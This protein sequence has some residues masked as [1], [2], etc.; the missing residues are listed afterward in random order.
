MLACAALIAGCDDTPNGNGTP[1]PLPTTAS[2]DTGE[3]TTEGTDTETAQTE[4]QKPSISIANAPIGGSGP[5][6]EG[7]EQCV[8]VNWLG[9]NPLPDG[10]TVKLGSIGLDPE[11]IFELYQSAC[12]GDA[13]RCTD[14][15]WSSES[16]R[17]C[18]VGGRQVANG[19]DTVLVIISATA[20]CA[21]EDDC[22]SLTEGAGQSSVG[23]NPGEL[24]TPTE[25][26]SDG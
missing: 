18:Y 26:P 24:E 12:P 25:T 21:T 23:F 4:Q 13:R 7:V 5:D 17:P 6:Q 10:T 8:E 14:L 9:K 11:G 1:T 19:N 22:N 15:V 2:E 20:T 16:L 3:P